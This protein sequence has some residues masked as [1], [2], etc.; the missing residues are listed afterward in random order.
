MHRFLFNLRVIVKF[1]EHLKALPKRTSIMIMEVSENYA[2]EVMHLH[3]SDMPA[4]YS[5]MTIKI[6]GFLET[7]TLRLQYLTTVPGHVKEKA[8]IF[9]PKEIIPNYSGKGARVWYECVAILDPETVKVFQLSVHNNNLE[10]FNTGYGMVLEFGTPH[11]TEYETQKQKLAKAILERNSAVI[12]PQLDEIPN[13]ACPNVLLVKPEARRLFITDG[14]KRIASIE[15]PPVM[16]SQSDIRI[17]YL[18]NVVSTELILYREYCEGESVLDRNIVFQERIDSNGYLEKNVELSSGGIT[19]R[20]DVFTVEYVL[21]MTFDGVEAVK[22]IDV[23]S[24]DTKILL[25]E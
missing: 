13:F 5:G 10:Y 25:E 12:V 22:K 1:L 24:E 8:E 18:K 7:N 23:V 6:N 3:F 11:N 15:M 21:I 20:N 19:M 4:D 17:F 9:L 2:G 14:G 16:R